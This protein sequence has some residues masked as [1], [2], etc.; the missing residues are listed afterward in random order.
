MGADIRWATFLIR[1]DEDK[2]TP[3]YLADH[4]ATRVLVQEFDLNEIPAPCGGWKAHRWYRVV[5]DKGGVAEVKNVEDDRI[6]CRGF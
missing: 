2:D 1:L 6:A 5:L 4:P 3:Y